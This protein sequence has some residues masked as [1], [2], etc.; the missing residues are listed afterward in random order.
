MRLPESWLRAWVPND[1]SID[2]IADR[3]TMAGLEV[4]EIESRAPDFTGVVLAKVLAAE[5]HPDADRLRVCTVDAGPEAPSLQIICGAP[6]A[7]AGIYVACARDGAVLPGNFKIKQA[8][9]RGVVSQGMLCSGKELGMTEDSEGILE[10]DP[11]QSALG[12]NIRDHLRLD[13]KT[14]VIKLTPNRADCLSMAGVARE[15]SALIGKPMVKP[16]YVQKP[17]A[18][19]SDLSSI[20]VTIDPA[21]QDL[22]GRFVSRVLTGVN[23]KAQAPDWMKAR[24]E[25][26]GQRSISALVDI[27]NYVMLELGQ[28]NHIFD[29]A[30]LS[31]DLTV[32]WAKAGEQLVLLN[33][34]TVELSAD[35]GVVADANGPVS[36]AGIMG[37]DGCAVSD[38]T[39]EVVLEAAFWWPDA[40]RGRA[41]RFKFSTDAGHRFERGVDPAAT[42]DQMAVLTHLVLQICGGQA[43]PVLDQVVRLPEA[44]SVTMRQARCEK[45]LGRGYSR[46]Q[47]ESVFSG[48]GFGFETKADPAAADKFIF[49]VQAPSYR[50]D[51]AIEEDLIEEV[52][53]IIGFEAIDHRPP[54]ASLVM[55]HQPEGQRTKA[56][57]R[58]RM[59]AADYN[60]VVTYSFIDRALAEAF[61]KP[62]QL[63]P[64]QNPIAAQ[65]AVMRPS[66][67]PGLLTALTDNLARKEPR[68]RVFEIGR[69]FL[70]DANVAAGPWSVKGVSQPLQLA[71]LAYGDALGEQWA[72]PSRWVDFFDLKADLERLVSPLSLSFERP[73]AVAAGEAQ[74]L[75]ANLHPGRATLVLLA[76]QVIGAMG[77][78]HPKLCQTLDLAKAP[79]VFEID[80]EAVLPR[81]IAEPSVLSKFPAVTRDLAFVM[82]EQTAAGQVVAAIQAAARKAPKG[83]R[84]QR[85]WAF[86]QYRGTG[87]SDQEKSLAF[88]FVL[89]DTEKTLEDSEVDA[90]MAV[91]SDT[92]QT[93]FS[94]R[95]RR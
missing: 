31:G 60:E 49:T 6:N 61:A 39:N 34:Q 70:R 18:S 79:V 67:V 35:V 29:K 38:D 1:L 9:M 82:P 26:A 12:A 17:Q 36:L 30:K 23:A 86:D 93:A 84:L 33:G 91:F 90:L 54:V 25:Q 87:L 83:E 64:L 8:K 75:L 4:E 69:K 37:G 52:A 2:E 55:A 20:G 89:Q 58:N 73:D 88:R 32:R 46:E 95:V 80:L 57:M 14:L 7:R 3:L 10:L 74:G 47:I 28:P 53:R 65:M 76:G 81:P 92:V 62:D 51:L 13:E 48:L 85:V 19:A 22:C 71:A 24:L 15:L 40:I 44:Q 94:A 77:E 50:F 72:S 42:A 5:K 63:L 21:A 27:S 16:D 59:V 56:Q 43:G 66:L 45:I 41:N 78:L 11:G 68:V